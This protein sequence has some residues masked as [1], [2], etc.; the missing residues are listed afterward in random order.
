MLIKTNNI[1]S[2][3][4]FI[5]TLPRILITLNIIINLIVTIVMILHTFFAK[6]IPHIIFYILF[7]T[8]FLIGLYIIIKVS[9]YKIIINE[10][11][12]TIHSIFKK[13][14][15][16]TFDDIVFVKREIKNTYYHLAEKIIIKNTVGKKIIVE[17]LC[18]NYEKFI[19]KVKE[20]VD[21][22]KLY[23]F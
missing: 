10:K 20:N 15:T 23:G 1:D 13:P 3:D 5:I 19:V 6:E 22:S 16:F 21:D 11:N 9:T 7:G 17:S 2:N 18:Q 8:I 14:Y 12:I 4:N